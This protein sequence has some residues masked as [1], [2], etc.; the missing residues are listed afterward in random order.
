MF[1]PHYYNALLLVTTVTCCQE[2]SKVPT[3][4]CGNT[5]SDNARRCAAVRGGKTRAKKNP[6]ESGV[7]G[8]REN[9][10]AIRSAASFLIALGAVGVIAFT[11][12]ALSAA[13]HAACSLSACLRM[14]ITCAAV[15]SSVSRTRMHA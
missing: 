4:C 9:Q 14:W 12:A 7:Y 1:S 8:K 11:R 6:A 13:S 3:V 10:A 15:F 5:L 2:G